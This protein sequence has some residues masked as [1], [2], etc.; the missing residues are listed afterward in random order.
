MTFNL[1]KNTYESYRKPDN[2]PVYINVNSNHS[3]T[4]IRELIKSIGKMLSELSC[5]QEILEK[6]ILPYTDALKKSGFKEN[7]V[8]APKTTTNNILDK[9]ERKPKIIWFNP[10]YSINVKTNS[11]K[12]FSSLLKK[13]FPKKNKLHKIFNKNNVKISYS[14]MSNI[15]SIIAGHNKSLLQPKITKYGCNCRV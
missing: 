11:G 8:Y 9:K 6:A 1:H 15:S 7:L 10:P 2:Q 14:C 12:I 4:T 3:P 5:N 13:H